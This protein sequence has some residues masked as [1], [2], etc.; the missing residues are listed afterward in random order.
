MPRTTWV[1][2]ARK[3]P[4]GNGLASAVETIGRVGLVSFL[5]RS[6]NAERVVERLTRSLTRFV[7]FLKMTRRNYFPISIAAAS[8]ACSR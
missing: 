1:D 4:P 7:F 2:F 3:I 5:R 6:W 8:A